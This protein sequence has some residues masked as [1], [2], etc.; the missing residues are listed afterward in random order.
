MSLNY[1]RFLPMLLW[2][3]TPSPQSGRLHCSGCRRLW[4]KAKEERD[5][6]VIPGLKAFELQDPISTETTKSDILQLGSMSDRHTKR[7]DSHRQK[8][9]V[10][11][12]SPAF[13]YLN[14][15]IFSTAI[16]DSAHEVRKTQS[17]HYRCVLYSSE[18]LTSLFKE[19]KPICVP[20][21]MKTMKVENAK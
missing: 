7:A 12:T 13:S 10:W 4:E 16:R 19:K 8:Q 9:E 18:I 5:L 1:Q 11:R 6:V 3:T 14:T 20:L 2:R 17:S 21:S 15:T